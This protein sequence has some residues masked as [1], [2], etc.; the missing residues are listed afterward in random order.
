MRKST[1]STLAVSCLAALLAGSV[2]AATVLVPDDD[3]EDL[4][5]T[6]KGWGER[7]AHPQGK[8][9]GNGQAATG[10]AKTNNIAYHGG[11]LILG[12]TNVYYIW[13]GNW[14]GNSAP[15]ILTDLASHIGGSPYFNINTT[16]YD[17]TGTHVT[18]AVSY[19]GSTTDAYSFGTA[20]SDSAK[21]R[22]AN[23]PAQ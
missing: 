6:G 21:P 17:A 5:P 7:A 11:P 9:S 20:L 10:K 16:Y 14:S 22:I 3:E 18:N 15:T 23:L 2:N 4:V 12:T 1:L 8:G 19:A 13:Y